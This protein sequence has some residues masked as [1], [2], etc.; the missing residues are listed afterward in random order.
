[1]VF[2]RLLSIRVYLNLKT[3]QRIVEL[4]RRL[5]MAEQDLSS[6]D[7]VASILKGFSWEM[8]GFLKEMLEKYQDIG[9]SQ[10]NLIK[11]IFLLARQS[12]QRNGFN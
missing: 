10:D 2:Q 7:L 3:R 6:F 11:L 9:L 1:L 4:F 5:M 8:E 12:Q